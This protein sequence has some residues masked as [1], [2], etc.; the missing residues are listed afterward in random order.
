MVPT[1]L[2]RFHHI[3]YR[4]MD[5]GETVRFYTEILGLKFAAAHMAISRHADAGVLYHIFFQLSD[6]SHIAFF[7]LPEEKPQ[8]W[9]PHTPDWVQHI[10][11]EV[12]SFDVLREAWAKL[13]AA[14]VQV[15]GDGDGVK[16]GKI[17]S[18]IYFRDPSG[19]RL[20]MCVPH[21]LDPADMERHAW[22]SLKRW[23]ADKSI[24]GRRR[25]ADPERAR[26][27]EPVGAK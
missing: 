20:E 27:A 17:I 12:E 13:K 25:A 24:A 9:D 3:A 23:D 8:G 14:G 1:P 7:E 26:K 15:E 11:F 21:D 4:C 16:K 18:S 5:S 2:K 22:D 6:G 10:A 19:H